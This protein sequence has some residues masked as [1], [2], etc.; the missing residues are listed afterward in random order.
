VAGSRG[1]KEVDMNYQITQ[2]F[3]N[4]NRSYQIFSPEG[5]VCHETATPGATDVAERS[6]FNNNDVKANAHAF[7]DYDSTLQV[8]PWNELG[9][10]AGYTANHKFLQI[11]LCHFDGARFM[12][13]WNRGVWTFAWVF[14]NVLGITTIT[15][16]NLMSHQEVSEKWGET[17][18][19]DPYGF[20]LDNGKTIDDFRYAVQQE[21]NEQL[22][23]EVDMIPAGAKECQ[24]EIGD[25][26]FP[27]YVLTNKTC[28][29]EG[30]IVR[31]VLDA[32]NRQ[33]TWDSANFKAIIK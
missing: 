13:V 32:M 12:E 1:D 28:F 4:K 25:K 11:E 3:I 19:S 30:V 26:T 14:I 21:I 17:D 10:G 18:H 33:L 2:N 31:E 6:Y 22:K 15:P 23:G 24:I 16:D 20:F 29:Q 27:G 7:I 8:L 9:W 5:A